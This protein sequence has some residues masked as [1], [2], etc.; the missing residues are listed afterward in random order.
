MK[1]INIYFTANSWMSETPDT[2]VKGMVQNKANSII[3]IIDENGYT[4]II[5]LD[6]IFAI[7]F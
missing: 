5:N 3:E 4:Q 1:E 2:V 7:V 6:K